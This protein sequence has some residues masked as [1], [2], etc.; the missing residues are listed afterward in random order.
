MR[1]IRPM[2][3]G[4]SLALAVV[5]ADAQVSSQQP[6]ALAIKSQILRD[7]LND[8]ARQTGFQLIIP[9]SEAA[10]RLIAPTV[11]GNLTP[12]AAL[13]RLLE[14]TS[15]TYE[16]LNERIVVIR[17]N[18]KMQKIS[19]EYSEAKPEPTRIAQATTPRRAA[20]SADRQRDVEEVVVTAQKRS[21][22]LQDVPISI[23]VLDGDVVEKASV[24]RVNDMS[25]LVP[26]MA[27]E[28]AYGSSMDNRLTIR[29]ITG[30][31]RN[32]GF[33]SGVSVYVD[34]VYAGRPSAQNL[35]LMDI[36]RV[37][38]LRGP[39]GTLF[40]K[41]TIAGVINV[42]TKK[43]GDEVEGKVVANIGNYNKVSLSGNLSGPLIDQ[44]LYMGGSVY[45]NNRDGYVENFYGGDDLGDENNYGG[46]LKLR[47]LA[48][49]SVEVN[50]R[51]DYLKD[52]NLFLYP[53]PFDGTSTMGDGIVYSPGIRTVNI[54]GIPNE[55][56]EV[57]G[58]ALTVD[59]DME[60][61]TFTSIS[62]YNSSEFTHSEDNDDSPLDSLLVDGWH[63]LSKF[64]SQEFR[65]ASPTTGK[66]DY[67]V[68]AYFFW[69]SV[70]SDVPFRTGPAYPF[71]GAGLA[72]VYSDIESTGG[73][74][75]A[76]T[77]YHVTDQ[78][79]LTAGLRYTLDR[80]KV[81]DYHATAFGPFDGLFDFSSFRDK[82]EDSDVS[83]MVSLSYAFS[84]DATG[85]IKAAR[86]FKSGGWNTD[87][88][89]GGPDGTPPPASALD[90]DPEYATT[91]EIGFK[92][93]LLDR[94]VTMN[95]AAFY[96][97]YEDLQVQSRVFDTT[98][99]LYLYEFNNAA[100]S[101]IQGIEVEGLVQF[102]D[103]F[104][105]RG[106]VGYTDAVYESF[107]GASEVNGVAID[108]DD[109]RLPHAPK[110]NSSLMLTYERPIGED[111]T[112]TASIDH[113][114]KD[115]FFTDAA[116]DPDLEVDSRSTIGARVGLATSN[117]W[118]VF[119]WGDNLTDK[120]YFVTK[121]KGTGNV[122]RVTWGMPRTYGVQ[123]GYS[124]G[125]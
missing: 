52:D 81:N 73:A 66:F 17:D 16:L 25:K 6:V 12:S 67:L 83:P 71:G 32:A 49:D 10:N 63:E 80:K 58:M 46:N 27:F 99:N 40:G 42:V 107:K 124:F 119:L 74:L 70:V 14:G 36:E 109:N 77:N 62:A 11:T 65:L 111:M 112:L 45:S 29:G 33:E 87:Y 78:L 96:T 64:A 79:T 24:T 75:F 8:W 114:F 15:L 116:N 1:T 84:E 101:T 82:R 72:V 44:K 35:N 110:W 30:N 3:I 69:Q 113:S 104:S 108:Y 34:G 105:L 47:Y 98:T 22:R 38:V 94:R 90:F 56:R 68:G 120:D 97:D 23:A 51:A 117:S 5:T 53:E 92:S 20:A 76:H 2:V 60:A 115:S 86:G 89:V 123:F 106:G 100:T 57:Y 88:V 48:S 19:T 9:S 55:Q 118:E 91:Y 37:E 41:N 21:E 18:S 43:P 13:A 93:S 61:L 125:K 31:V 103:S 28:S 102:T 85:Y 39:Q 4:A 50:F 121:Q 54:D 59:Y 7:A 26:N 95:I 122:L